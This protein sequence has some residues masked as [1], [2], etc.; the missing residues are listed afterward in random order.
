M[1]G[2]GGS[3]AARERGLGERTPRI[4]SYHPPPPQGPRARAALTATDGGQRGVNASRR[5]GPT[6]H[7]CGPRAATPSR[8]PPRRP[9]QGTPNFHSG[10][11]T[12]PP[13]P[14]Q[15]PRAHTEGQ[16]Q[17]T[18]V[19]PRLRPVWPALRTFRVALS[20]AD[21]AERARPPTPPSRSA[22]GPRPPGPASTSL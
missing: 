12:T 2:V 4:L 9:V 7:A 14:T 10:L 19:P 1:R 8:T 11:P 15:R 5:A 22:C 21:S 16:R 3:P 18:E 6:L 20:S 17:G 13:A